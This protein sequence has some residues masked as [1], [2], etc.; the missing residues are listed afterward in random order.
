MRYGAFFRFLVPL[1]SVGLLIFDSYIISLGLSE[2]L[3]AFSVFTVVLVLSTAGSIYSWRY[4]VVI[5]SA[6]ITFRKMFSLVIVKWSEITQVYY[7][8]NRGIVVKTASKEYDI[9]AEYMTNRS[10]LAHYLKAYVPEGLRYGAMDKIV[11]WH[12]AV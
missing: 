7:L 1:C 8:P 4:K 3:A 12:H 10:A 5:D 9:M 6:G 2:N 11:A